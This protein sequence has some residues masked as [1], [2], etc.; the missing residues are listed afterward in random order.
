MNKALKILDRKLFKLAFCF[1]IL[2]I[3]VSFLQA[4]VKAVWVPIW[5]IAS[6]GEKSTNWSLMLKRIR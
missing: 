4:K 1:I 5:D 3:F 6:P 2:C